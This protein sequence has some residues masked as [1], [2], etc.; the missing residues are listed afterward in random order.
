[1]TLLPNANTMWPDYRRDSQLTGHSP[2]IGSRLSG[3]DSWRINLGGSLQEVESIPDGTGDILLA[4]GGGIQRMTISGE[5]IWRSKPFGAHWITGVYDLDDD[6]E[7][8]IV[9]S[10]A[11]EVLILSATTG[12]ILWRENVG[13]PLSYGTYATMFQVHQLLPNERGMQIIVPCFSHK[14]VLIF[15]PSSGARE[16]KLL[17]TLWMD[18][19]YHPTACIGDVNSDGIEE[20]VI[21]RLGGVYVFDPVS[22]KMLDQTQWD[23]DEQRRRNYGHFE[24]CDLDGDGELEAV[25]LSNRVS[26]HIAVLDNDGHGRFHPLWDRFIQHIYPED[27]TELRYTNNSVADLNGDG[28]PELSV[29][30]YNA[31][32]DERWYTEV[33]DPI[34]GATISELADTYLW[35]SQSASANESNRLL[36]SKEFSRTPRTLSDISMQQWAGEWNTLWSMSNAAFA[37]K[38]VH[39][40]ARKAQFKPDVFASDEVWC[41]VFA[42]EKTLFALNAEGVCMIG[43]YSAATTATIELANAHKTRIANIRSDEL[44]LTYPNG[45]LKSLHVSGAARELPSQGYHLTT[46]AHTAA[47]PGITATTISHKGSTYIAVPDFAEQVHLY[48]IENGQP[49]LVWSVNGRSRVGYDGVYHAV[50]FIHVDDEPFIVIVDDAD[51]G[52][53]RLSLYSLSGE[54]KR[55]F[56]FEELPESIPGTRVG[57]YDWIPFEHSRGPALFISFFQSLSMNSECSR[58]VLLKDG[59]TLWELVRSGIGEYGRGIGAWGTSAILSRDGNQEVLLCAKDTLCR[60]DLETG[61]FSQPTKLLTSFTADRM[62]VLGTY[63][64]QGLKTWSSID[65]PFTAYGTPILFDVNRDGTDEIIIAGC[66]G[67]F[68][69]L[70]QDMNALWWHVAPFG[71]VVYRMPGLCDFDSDGIVELAVGH[72]TGD[73]V[74][75]NATTGEEK[76]RLALGAIATDCIT[77]DIDGDGFQ[78]F[79]T[80]TNDGRV[81]VIGFDGK[82]CV[83]K[84]T[85]RFDTGV[86]SPVVANL[87]GKPTII[88][89]SGDGVLHALV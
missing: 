24:L 76:Y 54:R 27:T 58:A 78:E 47:R 82:D 42:G 3:D 64:K 28:K 89:I 10:N 55:S 1:M 36:L 68:G 31:R 81:L 2:L 21:A 37:K 62:K 72:S 86:G 67:G 80:G 13:L 84:Q 19:A 20:I 33:I 60:I 30:L 45:E 48:K 38:S 15:D 79:I 14:E 34:S 51:L 49:H 44:I 66:F 35:G 17:H 73:F 74:I 12:E 29:S 53:A 18:D 88:I 39:T 7:F 85:Y 8:E 23:S 43:M 83:I 46:E 63:K 71:D 22:G 50:S 75:Y 61:T 77:C 40:S 4:S 69:V 6:G 65:D 52:H 16:T 87:D 9:T 41:E 11:M 56:E 5:Y 26:R 70:T 25:I 57:A 59:S 32:G